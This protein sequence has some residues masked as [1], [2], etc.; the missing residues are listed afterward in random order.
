[1]SNYDSL[2]AAY[3]QKIASLEVEYNK[4]MGDREFNSEP[5]KA[6]RSAIISEMKEL[7]SKISDVQQALSANAKIAADINTYLGS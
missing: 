3:R 6:R 7:E 5:S 2:I 4:I 1:M